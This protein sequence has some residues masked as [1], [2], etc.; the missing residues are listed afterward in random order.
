MNLCEVITGTQ[1]QIIE[2]GN[3]LMKRGYEPSGS[4]TSHV[5]MPIGM[6]IPFGVS[7]HRNDFQD[8]F[9][10]GFVLKDKDK[11]DKWERAEKRRRTKVKK[12]EMVKEK[13]Q[14]EWREAVNKRAFLFKGKKVKVQRARS[15]PAGTITHA[16][17]DL[18]G[19]V[20]CTVKLDNGKYL[21]NIDELCLSGIYLPSKLN[22]PVD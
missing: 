16:H 17:S 5:P 2:H 20:Y 4:P 8:M 15:T 13:K 11:Y 18:H 10:W 22:E 12:E 21:N 1:K 9:V 6:G 3:N 7:F 19:N 14:K